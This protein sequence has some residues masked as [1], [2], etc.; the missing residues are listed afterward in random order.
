MSNIDELNRVIAE[1]YLEDHVEWFDG[2]HKVL[3]VHS[4]HDLGMGNRSESVWVTDGHIR[5]MELPGEWPYRT[6]Q[7]E[8]HITEASYAILHVTAWQN[9]MQTDEVGSLL[10]C[11][12]TDPD[13]LREKLD[14]IRGHNMLP[15][16]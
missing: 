3:E 11:E 1:Y 4:H 7:F 5:S 16:S 2:G 14:A 15:A 13:V 12:D 6:K 8:H 10:I 9:G